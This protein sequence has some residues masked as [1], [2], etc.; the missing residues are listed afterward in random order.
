MHNVWDVF[1]QTSGA[2]TPQIFRLVLDWYRLYLF[3]EMTF[4]P[5]KPQIIRSYRFAYPLK[6]CRQKSPSLV[7]LEFNLLYLTLVNSSNETSPLGI[8]SIPPANPISDPRPLSFDSFHEPLTGSYMRPC[9]P[10]R[11]S[12]HRRPTPG[13]K[14][15]LS[16]SL[17]V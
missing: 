12:S 7:I 17:P 9:P 5:D 13:N 10:G 1:Q 4:A 14:H 15:V 11:G 3:D 6:I 8:P 16:L 2:C